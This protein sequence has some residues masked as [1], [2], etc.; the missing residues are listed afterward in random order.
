MKKETFVLEI[1][2]EYRSTNLKIISMSTHRH[3]GDVSRA[4]NN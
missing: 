3:T 2:T 4:E 1:G